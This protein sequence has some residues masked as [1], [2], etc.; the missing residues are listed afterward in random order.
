[1]AACRERERERERERAKGVKNEKEN[2]LDPVKG[3]NS[4]AHKTHLR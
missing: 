4:R 2:I 3:E 1:M